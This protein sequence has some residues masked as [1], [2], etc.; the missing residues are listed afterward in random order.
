MSDRSPVRGWRE[1]PLP[2]ERHTPPKAESVRMQERLAG[3][4]LVKRLRTEG[5]VELAAPPQDP[6]ARL[7]ALYRAMANPE[8][9][10]GRLRLDRHLALGRFAYGFTDA[11][12]IDLIAECPIGTGTLVPVGHRDI[13]VARLEEADEPVRAN[14]NLTIDRRLFRQWSRSPVPAAA[15]PVLEAA[16]AL[17]QGNGIDVIPSLQ[18][19]EEDDAAAIDAE[20]LAAYYR[21][22]GVPM[23]LSWRGKGLGKL[24]T[25]LELELLRQYK[26]DQLA[27]DSQS[28]PLRSIFMHLSTQERTLDLRSLPPERYLDLIVPFLQKQ[29]SVSGGG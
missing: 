24:L 14:G 6:P 5:L 3:A 20:A 8:A 28:E 19:L 4:D 22:H 2:H 21:Q 10:T 16:D 26:V 7:F 11:Y 12:V 1:I 18:G 27:L 9:P 29:P 23:G 25:G 15:V 17:W 13:L